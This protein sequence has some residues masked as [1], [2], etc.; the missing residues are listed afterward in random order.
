VARR[1]PRQT[2]CAH[3]GQRS[4]RAENQAIKK[5]WETCVLKANGY[6]PEWSRKGASNAMFSRLHA[7][8]FVLPDVMRQLAAKSPKRGAV[9]VQMR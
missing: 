8:E 1:E 9:V 5:A 4:W 7:G 2:D 3:R 6:E